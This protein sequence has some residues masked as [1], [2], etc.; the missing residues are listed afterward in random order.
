MSGN[1]LT[2]ADNSNEMLTTNW[3]TS[4]KHS[5]AKVTW[6]DAEFLPDPTKLAISVGIDHAEDFILINS[7]TLV[8]DSD[9]V[10]KY[11]H[12]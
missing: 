3:Q 4:N 11:T 1:E 5:K 12:I 9:S 10:F 7:K 6:F 8:G 2:V